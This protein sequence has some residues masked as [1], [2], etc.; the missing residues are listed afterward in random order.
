MLLHEFMGDYRGEILD[1]CHADLDVIECG[2][3]LAPYAE[4]FFDEMLRAVRRDSGVR[5]SVS[6]LP[7]ASEVA[8]R[9]GVDRQRAGVPVTRVPVIF[10]VLSQA[11]GRVGEKC[12]LTISA[13]EYQILNRCLDAGIAT[14]IENFWQRDKVRESQLITE[15]FGFIA[16][17]LR[18][19]LGN[20]NMAFRLLRSGN[21]DVNGRTA[22][23]LA[24]N[25]SRMGALIAQCLGS[26]QLEA[27]VR[28]ELVP[29]Q[30]AA[31]LRNLE[32]SAI[33]ERDVAIV[34]E[35]DEHVFVLASDTLL[36][37]ALSN[38]LS[39]A[40]KFSP[41]AGTV[42]M[43]VYASAGTAVIEVE[44]HGGGLNG[45]DAAQ[46]FEPYVKRQ[47]EN[48]AGTGLGLAIAKRA[49]EAMHGELAVL[50]KPKEGCIFSARFPTLTSSV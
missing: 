35:L 49:V 23:V 10:S 41:Q 33:P 36:T 4:D 46:I 18:N 37:S 8:A 22:D 25:L 50:D 15:W 40:I 13:E 7:G 28:P 1:A 19:A 48:S 47:A 26:V 32:A 11:I 42:W 16:H 38:L 20:A 31:V 29:V 5:E 39:N 6:P 24:R 21:L 34:L 17:D 44:D 30:L 45:Q 43:R 3:Q 2:A 27:G 12:E 9:F 14:S